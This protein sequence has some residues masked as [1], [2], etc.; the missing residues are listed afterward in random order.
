MDWYSPLHS[1]DENIKENHFFE[2]NIF[3]YIMTLFIY[4][5]FVGK[6]SSVKLKREEK[7]HDV[8]KWTKYAS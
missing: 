4:T 7:Q 6:S 8:L 3:Q 5:N 2:Y 1:L